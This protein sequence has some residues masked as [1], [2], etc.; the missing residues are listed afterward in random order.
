[1]ARWQLRPS[2]GGFGDH[3]RP[4]LVAVLP[5]DQ[6]LDQFPPR[7]DP[8]GSPPPS[9]LVR[10]GVTLRSD[11]QP[12]TRPTLGADGAQRPGSG[13]TQ[14]AVGW[15]GLSACG[16]SGRR[17][18]AGGA[19]RA[20]TAAGIPSGLL[21][22][23][24]G[25]RS[26]VLARPAE[27][28]GTD[29]R[30]GSAGG[31]SMWLARRPAAAWDGSLPLEVALQVARQGAETNSSPDLDGM[32]LALQGSRTVEGAGRALQLVPAGFVVSTGRY[33]AEE[34][35]RPCPRKGRPRTAPPAG[36]PAVEQHSDGR[37]GKGGAFPVWAMEGEI[38]PPSSRRRRRH[39]GA[40]PSVDRRE[41]I[42]VGATTRLPI[43]G[44]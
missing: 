8:P 10:A 37:D 19:A 21:S 6:Y 7:G 9:R 30:A 23:A 40:G 32:P 31:P 29:H 43:P 22:S 24:R 12:G 36:A 14:A 25:R 34:V 2:Y 41:R 26:R 13:P 42:L 11:Y 35:P 28:A 33:R 1:V 15:R 44:S 18:S 16:G 27:G 3:E 38:S 5:P 39:G 17:S 4:Y 20:A